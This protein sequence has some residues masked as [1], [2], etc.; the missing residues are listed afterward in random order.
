MK[1][2]DLYLFCATLIAISSQLLYHHQLFA[3]TGAITVSLSPSSNSV[4]YGSEVTLTATVSSDVPVSTII[5]QKVSGDST[6]SNLDT[7]L[8]KYDQTGDVGTG[9]VKLTIKGLNFQD[10][11]NYRV[12]VT[13]NAG[14][15]KTSDPLSIDVTGGM[16][17]QYSL[18]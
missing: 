16:C 15:K 7:N 14:T 8:D 12:E 10:K 6:T 9:T 4:L 17:V 5:W 13:N 11:G 18:S 3:S 1:I 2:L